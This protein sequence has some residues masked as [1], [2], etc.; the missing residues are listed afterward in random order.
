LAARSSSTIPRTS[1]HIDGFSASA[2]SSDVIDVSGINFNASDFTESYNAATHQFTMSDGTQTASFYLDYFSNALNFGGDGH[3]G[4]LITNQAAGPETI[5]SGERLD[6]WGLSSVTIT[7]AA[8]TGGLKIDNA[9]GFGGHIAGFTGT[10]ADAAHS[11]V[12]DL[13]GIDYNAAGFHETYDS[14]TGKFTVTDGTNNASFTFDNF[15]ATLKFASDGNGGTFIFDP[16]AGGT[17]AT[18]GVAGND[19]FRW[20]SEVNESPGGG[21]HLDPPLAATSAGQLPQVL[22]RC[23]RSMPNRGSRPVIRTVCW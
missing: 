15:T 3:G 5:A 2:T 8:G 21:I 16:P 12:I 19:N 17:A 23:C 14:T 11:D 20:V 4:T 1:G 9:A 7:F 13:V 22:H 6:V 10:Q 18:P